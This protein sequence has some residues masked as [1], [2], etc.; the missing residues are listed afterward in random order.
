MFKRYPDTIEFPHGSAVFES[1]FWM[2][3]LGSGKYAVHA[4]TVWISTQS[5][6]ICAASQLRS[7]AGSRA[8]QIEQPC[9]SRTF[10]FL[11][12]E[13]CFSPPAR[14]GL[15][16]FMSDAGS[17]FSSSSS[18]SSILAGPPLPALEQWASPDLHC[19]DCS[20]LRRTSAASSRSQ[21]AS[22]DLHCQL[23]SSEA[24]SAQTLAGWG[25]ARCSAI[26]SWQWRSG[27]AHCDHCD[28]EPARASPDLNRTSTAR[29]K[30]I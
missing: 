22:P 9:L 29:N 6:F 5:I 10:I 19:Q 1:R 3:F 11:I 25:P 21:W 27:E 24:H 14:W 23:K 30:A 4:S 18:C 28:R 7:A 12:C 26:E 20:D 17:S 16:D 2:L 13:K 8:G 15:L